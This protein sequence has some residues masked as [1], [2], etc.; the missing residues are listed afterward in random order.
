[1]KKHINEFLSI[2]FRRK[3][4]GPSYGSQSFRS[5]YLSAM[6]SGYRRKPCRRLYPTCPFNSYQIM[7]LVRSMGRE[8]VQDPVSFLASR[9]DEQTLHPG[10]TLTEPG[11]PYIRNLKQDGADPRTRVF[12]AQKISRVG[13]SS[14]T[15]VSTHN[16]PSP[17]PMFGH[18]GYRKS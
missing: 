2:L 7:A 13:S 17:G 12:G 14:K 5:L 15:S 3:P 16:R 8:L 4:T 11:S 9:P 1:M 6:K 18:I 10:K